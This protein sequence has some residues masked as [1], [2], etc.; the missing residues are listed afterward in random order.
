MN[1]RKLPT[2]GTRSRK[3]KAFS[4]EQ[5]NVRVPVAAR[6]HATWILS[7]TLSAIAALLRNDV[8]AGYVADRECHRSVAI[9]LIAPR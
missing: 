5:L 2:L 9:G 7:F 3:K 4:Y 6:L 1:E 8:L